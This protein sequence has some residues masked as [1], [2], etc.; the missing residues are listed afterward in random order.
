M[1]RKIRFIFEA[2]KIKQLQLNTNKILL[3]VLDTNLVSEEMLTASELSNSVVEIQF[4]EQRNA[5]KLPY[6]LVSRI[7]FDTIYK[8]TYNIAFDRIIAFGEQAIGKNETIASQ[9]VDLSGHSLWYHFRFMMLYKVRKHLIDLRI[10]DAIDKEASNYDQVLVYHD[11]NLI[12][13]KLKDSK[14]ESIFIR[15][16]KEKAKG[17]YQNVLKFGLISL[18]RFFIG[19]VGLKLLFQSTRKHVILSSANAEQPI[20]RRKDFQLKKGDHL[21]DYLQEEAESHKEF[22]NLS[23]FYPP[24]LKGGK[25]IEL[26]KRVLFST[27]KNTLNFETLFFLQALNPWFYAKSYKA[28]KQVK[29]AFH[30]IEHFSFSD[31]LDQLIQSVLVDYKRLSFY[32]VVRKV[33]IFWFLKV[34]K[35]HSISGTHEHDSK[36]KSIFEIARKQGIKTYGIQHG[37]I[38][39]RHLH[40]CFSKF[41]ASFMPF[42]DQT[43][44]WGDHWKNGLLKFSNY[45][46][47]HLAVVG[48][49]RTDIIA[50]LKQERKNLV[51]DGLSPTKKTIMYPSQPLYAGEEKMREK[52]AS[53]FL[54]LTKEFSELQFIVKPHPKE[55]DC[56]QF[57]DRLAQ[58]IGTSNYK[59]I[60]SDLYKLLAMSDLVIVYNSTVGAEAIYFHKPLV[61]MNYSDNDFS[62]FIKDGVGKEVNNYTALK[63]AI[64][65]FDSGK[66]VVNEQL[67]ADFIYNRAY[68]IDGEVSSRIIKTV[69]KND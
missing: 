10:A 33:A 60:R 8:E 27:Y 25:E 29:A 65:T 17:A 24:K 34:K 6:Q 41:D 26:S 46:S 59:V 55:E 57:F 53:D 28:I 3:L 52:L 15:R 1:K 30:E 31:E 13:K 38:H 37:V 58:Q 47:H 18:S 44:V 66:E 35:I 36:N 51:V 64:A 40:Y 48:Q 43:F 32:V 7:D 20:L 67:L 63:E 4:K 22:L 2:F 5:F 61:V 11:S 23:E 16:K 21:S 54:R 45:Q 62:G 69:I 49:I 56:E 39:F 12:E 9:L 14:V 42:P 50:Q 68:Q 19:L